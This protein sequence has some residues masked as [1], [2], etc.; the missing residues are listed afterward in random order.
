[1]INASH[2]GLDQDEQ[3]DA[4]G[5]YCPHGQKIVEKDPDHTD[6]DGYPIGRLV[7]PWPCTV[8]GCNLEAFEQAEQARE[9]EY[10]AALNEI[11]SDVYR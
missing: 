2:E 10:Y 6:P 1:M 5:V 9:E 8:D 7:T 11:A 4:W 3:K